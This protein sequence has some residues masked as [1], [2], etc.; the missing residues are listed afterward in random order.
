MTGQ[1]GSAYQVDAP[2][3]DFTYDLR[4]V[5]STAFPY[6]TLYPF[7]FGRSGMGGHQSGG[8]A[9]VHRG[10]YVVDGLRVDHPDG[11]V[12]EFEYDL[13]GRR[14]LLRLPAQLTTGTADSMVFT[15]DDTT[16][17]LRTIRDVLGRDYDAVVTEL[18]RGLAPAPASE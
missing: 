6:N 18:Q 16:S 5:V 14:T 3:S 7:V 8:H 10:R 4:G 13:N 9:P 17:E 12:T 15:Y 11:G 1:Q 2:T